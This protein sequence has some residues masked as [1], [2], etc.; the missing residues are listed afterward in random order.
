MTV[1]PPILTELA[2]DVARGVDAGAAA[3]AE[4][5]APRDEVL[6]TH[7]RGDLELYERLLRDDQV[8]P[9]FHQRRAAVIAREWKVDPGGDGPLDVLAADHLR[10]QIAR[11]SFDRISYRMLSGLMYG[12]GI[13]ECMF[14]QEAGR[15]V[16]TGVKVRRA[17]RFTFDTAGGLHLLRDGGA[18][19][20]MPERKFWVLTC[21]ADDDDN[22]HGV[23]LGH[24]LY[25]PVWLKRNGLRFWALFLERFSGPTPTAEVPAGATDAERQKVLEMLD[26]F[27]MGGR[28]VYSRGISL[29]L[30]QAVRDSGGDYLKFCDRMDAAIAKIVLTQTMTTE[31]GSSL[32]QGEVHERMGNVVAKSDADLLCES[33][34]R[35]PATWLTEWN[36]PGARTPV[37]YRDFS[38]AEDVA[39][40]ATRD[41]TLSRIGYLPTPERVLEVYGEGYERTAPVAA[42]PAPLLAGPLPAAAQ[43]APLALA[44]PRVLVDT[45]AAVEQLIGADGWRRL[46][47]PQVAEIEAVL[48][49]CRTL[50]QARARLTELSEREP[51]RLAEG[52]ARVMFAARVAGN[53]VEED[54]EP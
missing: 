11:M 51:T 30:Q 33:F 9:V 40:I 41:E 3:V 20:R 23:G 47:G 28:I 4:L 29:N 35:G 26:A 43:P 1:E 27:M 38:E 34:T 17:R 52:L 44:E 50:E 39:A 31:D 6:E 36:F 12:K 37:V 5:R 46:L 19:E 54:V 42:A 15:V 22:P 14:A 7:G 45:S 10:E 18:T 13:G 48:A 16:M 24:W 8:Y 53:A 49:D 21:G 25:Q 2:A 32:A